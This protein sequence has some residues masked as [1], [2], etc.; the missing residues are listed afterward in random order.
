M[1]GRMYFVR[2]SFNDSTD[3]QILDL[4][5]LDLEQAERFAGDLRY[6]V[7]QAREV[8]APVVQVS[9][10]GADD[11]TTFEPGRIVGIDLEESAGPHETAPVTER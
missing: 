7:E 8:S 6:E 9:V 10:P 4:P 11:A 2:V 3:D 1:I 5:G